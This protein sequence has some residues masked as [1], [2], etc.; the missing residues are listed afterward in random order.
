MDDTVLLVIRLVYCTIHTV[1][2]AFVP[3]CV[4]PEG[5]YSFEPCKG[6]KSQGNSETTG[7]IK[8]ITSSY[9]S[10]SMFQ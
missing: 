10:V 1:V 6:R 8:N 5:K 4:S 3:L 9:H 7:A 2:F